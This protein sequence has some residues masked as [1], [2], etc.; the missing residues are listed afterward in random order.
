MRIVRDKHVSINNLQFDDPVLGP[1]FDE[2]CSFID[3]SAHVMKGQYT[4][5]TSAEFL[6]EYNQQVHNLI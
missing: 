4:Y 3:G 2:S 6:A 5:K 1:G